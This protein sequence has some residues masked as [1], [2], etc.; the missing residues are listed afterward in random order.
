MHKAQFE[1]Q[2]IT[3]TAKVTKEGT[4]TGVESGSVEFYQKKDNDWTLIATVPVQ[5]EGQNMGVAAAEATMTLITDPGGR[6]QGR[7][8]RKVCAERDLCDLDDGYD[9]SDGLYQVR[10]APDSGHCRCR[11]PCPYG[12]AE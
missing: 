8:L 7:V 11:Q 6:G 5:P 3:L 4:Q 10:A 1:G 2:T 9:A 12:Q